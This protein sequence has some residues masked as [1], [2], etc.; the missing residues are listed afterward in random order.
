MESVITQA[1]KSIKW[2]VFA[3]VLPKLIS[4]VTTVILASLLLPSS[5]GIISICMGVVGFALLIQG[6]GIREFIIREKNVTDD[7]LSTAF[8]LNISL[9]IF[10]FIIIWILSPLIATLYNDKLI[11]SALRVIIIIIILNAAGTVQWIL[12]QKQMMLKKLFFIQL[13]PTVIKIIIVIPMAYSGYGIWS[14][15]IGEICK[16]IVQNTAYWVGC[17]WKPKLIFTTQ[18]ATEIVI[19]G[20]WVIAERTGEYIYSN[21]DRFIIGYFG[22]LTILGVYTIGRQIISMFYNM[23]NGPIGELSYPLISKLNDNP[24]TVINYYIKIQRRIVNL[25]IPATILFIL[26]TYLLTDIFFGNKWVGL[27]SVL[28][29]C[30]I[31]EGLSRTMWLQRD[32]YQIIGKPEIYPKSIIYNILFALLFYQIG[33]KEGLLLF[34]IIRSTNDVL[35]LIVQLFLTHKTLSISISSLIRIARNPFV[36]STITMIPASVLLALHTALHLETNVIV[37]LLIIT[38]VLITYILTYKSLYKAE[39]LIYYNDILQIFKLKKSK[40]IN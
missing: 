6:V 33:A 3:S 25:N 9:S 40:S 17:N 5:F 28:I 10:L 18:K 36:V 21:L 1:K 32:I 37:S 23:L 24:E 35:Y 11:S 29:I 13:L 12:L 19:F 4:P 22:N 14:L 16:C 26:S 30:G 2:A 27:T 38:I 7:I 34:C 20:K 31:G 15:A 8:W 39:Y